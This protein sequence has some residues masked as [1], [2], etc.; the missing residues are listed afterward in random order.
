MLTNS[1]LTLLRDFGRET[2]AT[3]G[4]GLC[5]LCEL[6]LRFLRLVTTTLAQMDMTKW[7]RK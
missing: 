1:L 4:S 2:M 3:F 7:K 5:T 6:R